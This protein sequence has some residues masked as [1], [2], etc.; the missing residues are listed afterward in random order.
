[1]IMK[2]EIND[3]IL[4]AIYLITFVIFSLI[5]PENLISKIEP[6]YLRPNFPVFLNLCILSLFSLI[7]I[8][9]TKRPWVGIAMTAVCSGVISI[10]NLYLLRFRNYVLNWGDLASI[11]TALNVADQYNFTPQTEERF[12]LITTLV[13]IILGIVFLRKKINVNYKHLLLYP[14]VVCLF[15]VVV[16]NNNFEAFFQ[17]Q[18]TTFHYNKSG[19][20]LSLIQS[21][22]LYKIDYPEDYSVELLE[23]FSSNTKIKDVYGETPQNIVVIMNESFSDLPFSGEIEIDNFNNLKENTIK[24]I[25]YTS[26]F[27]GSTANS[28]YEF[29]TSNSMGL[30][31]PYFMPYMSDK[32]IY[33]SYSIVRS[34]SKLG[35]ETVAFHPFEKT[36][37]NREEVYQNFHFDKFYHLENSGVTNLRFEAV[38]DNISDKASYQKVIQLYENKKKDKF[39]LF[40][41]TMQNHSPNPNYIENIELSDEDIMIL[42]DYFKDV[43]ENTM[44]VFFGDHQVAMDDSYYEK[45]LGKSRHELSREELEQLYTVPF[46]IWANY[47]IE[48]QENVKTSLNFLSTMMFDVANLPLNKYQMLQLEIM[49]FLPV[50]HGNG[51]WDSQGNYYSDIELLSDDTRNKVKLY[52]MIQ[53]QSIVDADSKIEE[54]F[55]VQTK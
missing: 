50:I 40:N 22:D 2:K 12:V 55:Y 14:V 25:A 48:E 32:I 8:L 21:Y 51:M 13:I 54:I 44:L 29:L 15:F 4:I 31:N 49:E 24:G 38:N 3:Y 33:N 7:F 11:E 43:D 36:G 19:Y 27:G 18:P 41:V 1:M 26:A 37:W 52:R 45:Y 34:L 5:F 39:F 28:E 35:Y 53:A 6:Y 9:I 23:E 30:M 47:D 46:F 20:I 10:L 16:L 17:I 42:I